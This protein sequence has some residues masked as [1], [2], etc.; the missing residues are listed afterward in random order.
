MRD[1]NR[2]DNI[3]SEIARLHKE[4]LPDWRVGQLMSNFSRWMGHEKKRDLFFPEDDKIMDY[5][6]EFVDTMSPY[7]RINEDEKEVIK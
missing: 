3:Y 1:P 6:I 2:F 4:Y 7:R 5:F